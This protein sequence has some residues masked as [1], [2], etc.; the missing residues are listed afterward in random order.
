MARLALYVHVSDSQG[1]AVVFGPGDEVPE[2]AQQV[3]TN[4]A[5][6]A[7]APV[8]R[9]TEPEPEP[10]RKEP[11]KRATPRRKAAGGGADQ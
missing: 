2:W 7:E 6:W 5:A 3:I 11:A 9:L 1:R 10:V 8:N 4:P